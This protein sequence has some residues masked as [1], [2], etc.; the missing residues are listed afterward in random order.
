MIG[1]AMAHSIASLMV[2][3]R[4]GGTDCRVRFRTMD[5]LEAFPPKLVRDTPGSVASSN[6]FMG[7]P[8]L[9]RISS[10]AARRPTAQADRGDGR[11]RSRPNPASKAMQS[12]NAGMEY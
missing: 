1:A 2:S 11:S 8:E 7:L 9:T 12:V 5:N 10:T 4:L 3:I 6:A